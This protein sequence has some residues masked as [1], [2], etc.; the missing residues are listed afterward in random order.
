MTKFIFRIKC[1]LFGWLYFVLGSEPCLL[2]TG[3]SPVEQ[4]QASKSASQPPQSSD[5][6]ATK[7]S[8]VNTTQSPQTTASIAAKKAEGGGTEGQKEWKFR[9]PPRGL[10]A[11][12]YSKCPRYH[13]QTYVVN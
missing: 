4:V 13:T 8:D 2:D 12:E 6:T 10:T 3:K 9:A 7:P 1:Y 5:N 11:Q